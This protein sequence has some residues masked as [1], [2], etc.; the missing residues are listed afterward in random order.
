MKCRA[1]G[2]VT[3]V[4][5]PWA[6]PGS[7]FSLLF[8]AF[9]LSLAPHMSVAQLASQLR[10][11]DDPLWRV[12]NHHTQAAR[13]QESYADVRDVGVDETASRAACMHNAKVEAMN[14]ALQ[15]ARPR[16]RRVDNYITMVF[17]IAG[18]LKHL[19]DNPFAHA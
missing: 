13:A 7:R 14:R 15:Q 2:K 19:P 8:E 12:L 3:Q 18:K 5:V 6:R 1:C 10:V 17:L 4:E 16:S 11:G 9:M